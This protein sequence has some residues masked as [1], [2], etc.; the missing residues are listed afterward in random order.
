MIDLWGEESGP[1]LQALHF[2]VMIGATVCPQLGKLFISVDS[3][4]SNSTNV[5]NVT[6]VTFLESQTIQSA[7]TSSSHSE[8]IL[9]E[10][11]TKVHHI[12]MFISLFTVLAAILHLVILSY[13]KC[14]L[15]HIETNSRTESLDANCKYGNHWKSMQKGNRFHSIIGLASLC[16]IV[17][18]FGGLEEIFGAFLISFSVNQLNRTISTGRDLVSVFWGSAATARFISI[19]LACCV[20]P[21]VLL[22][23][24]TIFAAFAIIIMTF[25]VNL[26]HVSI[27][28]GTVFVGLSIGSL[29]ATVINMGKRFLNFSGF[30]SSVVFVSMFIGKIATPPLMGYLLQ[31]KGYMW[32]MYVSAI[33]ASLMF[34]NYCVLLYMSMSKLPSQQQN[35][36]ATDGADTEI[37]GRN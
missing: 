7:N 35:Q 20:K 30:L 6:G 29:V 15:N 3:S 2:I 17:V 31:E 36:P 33:Y 16:L 14:R 23:T 34:V 1:Y 22:G 26:T 18:F 4:N 11:E 32:F 28:L 25:T 27:W 5:F 13:S 10:F 19:F 24:C 8:V 9:V 37:K 21:R 12:F